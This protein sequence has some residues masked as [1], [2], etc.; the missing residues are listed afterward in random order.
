ML[1]PCATGLVDIDD[2]FAGKWFSGV[3]FADE[4]N[5]VRHRRVIHECF[6]DLGYFFIPNKNH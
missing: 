3:G 4:G 5:D 6:M 2:D 1:G